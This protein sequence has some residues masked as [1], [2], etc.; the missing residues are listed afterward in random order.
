M[1]VSSYDKLRQKKL[2]I[3]I[4]KNILRAAK[5]QM[6]VKAACK[7]TSLHNTYNC[8]KTHRLAS[9]GGISFLL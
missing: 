8:K 5:M 4:K 6:L 7:S 3:I 9:V 1:Q 2:R